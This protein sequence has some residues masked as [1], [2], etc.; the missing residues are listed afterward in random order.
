MLEVHFERDA[1]RWDHVSVQIIPGRAFSPG[2]VGTHERNWSMPSY[3]GALPHDAVHLVVEGAF[4]L[5]GGLFGKVAQ[6]ADPAAVNAEVHAARRAG[7]AP[8]GFG[9]EPGE[10]LTAEALAAVH[11]YDP[12]A[13]TARLRDVHDRCADFGAVVPE[14]LTLERCERVVQVLRGLRARFRA[15]GER[16][17]V[18]S[19]DPVTPTRTFERLWVELVRVPA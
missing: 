19:F 3:G 12:D 4:G 2:R 8:R 10:L 11:W 5:R 13:G 1:R 7:R 14:T 9:P 17:L 16:A 6:G 15:G 18:L